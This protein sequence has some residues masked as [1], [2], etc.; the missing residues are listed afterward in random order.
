MAWWCP[1]GGVGLVVGD[2]GSSPQEGALRQTRLSKNELSKERWEE[3][4]TRHNPKLPMDEQ[5]SRNP[6]SRRCQQEIRK[7]KTPSG[8]QKPKTPIRGIW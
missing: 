4:G 7:L 6:G 2:P 8:I 1:D 3:S 5:D